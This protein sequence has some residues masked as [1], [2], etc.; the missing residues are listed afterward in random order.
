VNKIIIAV[1]GNI[2]SGKTTLCNFLKEFGAVVID[3]DA[4]ARKILNNKIIKGQLIKHF[5][6][7]I[8]NK[9]KNLNI[10]REK[11]RNLAFNNKNNCLQLNRITHQLI[12]KKIKQKI[13]NLK[14]EE[15][16]LDIPLLIEGEGM[17]SLADKIIVVVTEETLQKQRLVN[18][19]NKKEI[20]AIMN[21]QLDNTFKQKFAD[22]I[23]NNNSSIKELKEKAEQVWQQIKLN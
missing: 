6:K 10:S 18:I 20:E 16:I 8:L 11:L 21:Q 2:G 1:T 19:Y 5:G 17:F 13:Y 9:D 4:L 3:T 23:I 15:I 7:K 12:I 14:K 22:Y